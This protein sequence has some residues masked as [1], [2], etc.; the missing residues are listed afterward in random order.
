MIVKLTPTVANPAQELTAVYVY[1][2]LYLY[3]YVLVC[4]LC[5]CVH[6]WLDVLFSFLLMAAFFF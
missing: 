5:V 2:Y 1:I 6:M 4:E 3:T